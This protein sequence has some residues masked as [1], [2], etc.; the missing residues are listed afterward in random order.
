MR[1]VKSSEDTFNILVLFNTYVKIFKYCVTFKQISFST[2]L[3][4]LPNKCTIYINIICFLKQFYIY[5]DVYTSSS[6]DF[7]IIYR[8]RYS[9][10][11]DQM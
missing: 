4:Y 11:I 10:K 3:L 2:L 6:G 9:Y 1:E 7:L 5:I 8:V